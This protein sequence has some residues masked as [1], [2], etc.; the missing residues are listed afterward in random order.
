[1]N[2]AVTLGMKQYTVTHSIASAE[3]SPDDVV[4][5]P[6]CHPRDLVAAFGAQSALSEPQTQELIPPSWIRLHLQ[7]KAT[8]EVRFPTR[9]IGVSIPS[10]LDVSDDGD[11]RCVK[12]PGKGG[13]PALIPGS[14]P[15]DTPFAIKVFEILP[16][17]PPRGFVAM[18]SERPA[19]QAVEDC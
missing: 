7:V 12:E 1:M 8:L 4:A 13:F 3:D 10:N 6:P 5:A 14:F 19:P 18:P 15:E 17:N 11:G 9:V 16:D 2:L